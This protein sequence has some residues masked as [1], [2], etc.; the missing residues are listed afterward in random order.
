MHHLNPGFAVRDWALRR[1]ELRRCNGGMGPQGSCLP[2]APRPVGTAQAAVGQAREGAQKHQ[3][4][5]QKQGHQGEGPNASIGLG[6]ALAPKHPSQGQGR[7]GHAC[8]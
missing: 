7:H 6:P 2:I 4:K 8:K 5:G 3:V 1:S